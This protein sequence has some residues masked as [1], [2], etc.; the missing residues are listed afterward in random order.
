MKSNSVAPRPHQLNML[1][2]G[3]QLR[4]IRKQKGL[5]LQG[6]Q[7]LSDG[8][9][10]AVV[11]G[12]YERNDRTLSLKRAIEL[13]DFY[14]VPLTELLGLSS[15]Q[16]IFSRG[17][18][19]LDLRSIARKSEY[20]DQVRNIHTFTLWIC[21]RRRDWNGEI[22]SLRRDDLSLLAIVTFLAEAEVESLLNSAGLLFPQPILRQ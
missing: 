6:V 17:E 13:A 14:Q 18:L 16:G 2:I 15:D 20:D 8:R 11:V 1:E 9:W 3:A 4:A 21:A 19:R 22:L 10:K 7:K 5:T 12:S